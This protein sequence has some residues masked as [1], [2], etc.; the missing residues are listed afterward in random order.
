M[1]IT[2]WWLL[3]TS[4]VSSNS[5]TDW[6]L[7]I[8]SVVSS[9]SLTDW[10]LLITSVVSSNSLTDWWLLITSVVSSN[11]LTDW[12]LLITSVV[13]SILFS[14]QS[15]LKVLY[16]GSYFWSF[17]FDV[18]LLSFRLNGLWF[19]SHF[20]LIGILTLSDYINVSLIMSS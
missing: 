11:S 12:W 17:L 16:V 7:L 18:A 15:T 2:D 8:T 19:I 5:L 6:W 9:N 1:T 3:I 14:L 13:S 10:W 20:P 4:V